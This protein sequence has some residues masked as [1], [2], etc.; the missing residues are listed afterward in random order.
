[1]K[2]LKV[3]FKQCPEENV[4]YCLTE[5]KY[6]ILMDMK[7]DVHY[8]LWESPL[9]KELCKHKTSLT[10]TEKRYFNLV[11]WAMNIYSFDF[12][13]DKKNQMLVFCNEESFHLPWYDASFSVNVDRYFQNELFCLPKFNNLSC[14]RSIFDK[15]K[16][17]SDASVK[18]KYRLCYEN[19]QKS[20][21]ERFCVWR[22]YLELENEPDFNFDFDVIR[23]ALACQD[24]WDYLK[25]LVLNKENLTHFKFFS[26][27]E[28]PFLIYFISLIIE[29]TKN[30]D[31]V[32]W[33]TLIINNPKLQIWTLSRGW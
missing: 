17:E 2:F 28:D 31:A 24:L 13:Y 6:N 15:W 1:M 5:W 8:K 27:P 4:D 10:L 22:N 30:D 11:E 25:P 29:E 23:G 21:G 9:Y 32:R 12:F 16:Q 14:F 19:E 18:E 20:S 33:K 7:K 3:Y 26:S